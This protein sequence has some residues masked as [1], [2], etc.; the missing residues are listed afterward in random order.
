M[1][2]LL[3]YRVKQLLRNRIGWSGDYASWQEPSA[4]CAGYDAHNILEK[5]KQATLKVKSGEAVFERDSVIFDKIEYSFPLLSALL[6]VASM[7]SQRLSV[8][9]FGGSLGSSYF[10]NRGFLENAGLDWT[11]V[12]QK[13]F[14]EVGRA[15]IADNILHFEPTISSAMNAFHPNLF[16]LSCCI[17]YLEKPYELIDEIVSTKIPYIIL[18]NTPFNFESRDRITIQKV[19]PTIYTASYP[20]WFL[21]YKS[22]LD[23]FLQGYKIVTEFVNDTTIELDG[24]KIPYRGFLLELKK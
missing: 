14:V 24:H 4:K 17:Q 20:C 13:Q 9:D 15:S 3:K 22:V 7:Q 23:R 21:D 12:E 19:P 16:V 6:W 8:L 10:Q 2:S 18:D 5:V 1:I 11:I